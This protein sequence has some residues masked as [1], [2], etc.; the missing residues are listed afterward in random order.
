MKI[1]FKKWGKGILAS[2]MELDDDS[3]TRRRHCC[4]RNCPK[5]T[6]EASW[7]YVVGCTAEAHQSELKKVFC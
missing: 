4:E 1:A 5:R 7:I 3:A 2:T 6:N